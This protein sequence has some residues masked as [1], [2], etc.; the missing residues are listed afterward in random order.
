MIRFVWMV[1]D[2]AVFCHE[3]TVTA[4]QIVGYLAFQTF[5]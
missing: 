2:L 3:C 5:K 4:I 1:Y